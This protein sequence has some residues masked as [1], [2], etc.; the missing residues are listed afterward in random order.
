M[1]KSVSVRQVVKFTGK[2]R[3]CTMS[4]LSYEM[5]V[6]FMFHFIKIKLQEVGKHKP[7]HSMTKWFPKGSFNECLKKPLTHA[8]KRLLLCDHQLCMC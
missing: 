3:H 1:I 4:V 6:P 5:A 2:T 7:A 8:V